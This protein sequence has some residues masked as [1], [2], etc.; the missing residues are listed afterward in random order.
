[1]PSRRQTQVAEEIAH[2]AGQ[3]L[4]RESN[5]TSLV[6]VTRAD[7]SPDIKNAAIFLSVLPVDMEKPALDFAKRNRSEFR[8]YLKTHSKLRRLPFIDFEIDYG[9]KNR[10][11]V[12]ELTRH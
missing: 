12:D 11:R 10:Q 2:L 1:M 3:F 7:I 5:G 6:T 8:E 4:A 9:E